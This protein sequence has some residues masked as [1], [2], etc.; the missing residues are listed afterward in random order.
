MGTGTK[1]R[2]RDKVETN[3]P[4]DRTEPWRSRNYK[5]KVIDKVRNKDTARS[6]L[7]VRARG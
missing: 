6:E 5:N 1:A 2:L 3:E 7:R 4:H